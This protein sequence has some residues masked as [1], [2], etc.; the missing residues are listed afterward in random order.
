MHITVLYLCGYGVVTLC[1]IAS[2]KLVFI[3]AASGEFFLCLLAVLLL[4]DYFCY[5]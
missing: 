1:P 5:L 4:I 2:S 3:R